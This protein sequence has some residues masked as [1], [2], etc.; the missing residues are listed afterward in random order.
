MN[1]PASSTISISQRPR[2]APA[3]CSRTSESVVVVISPGSA[4]PPRRTKS[5]LILVLPVPGSRDRAGAG[6][7]PAGLLGELAQG[8]AALRAH[9]AAI[10][11]IGADIMCSFL[12]GTQTVLLLLV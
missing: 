12:Y 3:A 7:L 1:C 6:L 11:L 10:R 2:A 5:L 4:R 8:A 9:P